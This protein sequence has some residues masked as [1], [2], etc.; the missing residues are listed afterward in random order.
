[1]DD[2]RPHDDSPDLR[3]KIEALEAMLH[4]E[5]EALAE[6]RADRDAWKQQATALLAAPPNR[7]SWWP[8]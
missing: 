7:R 1:M 3:V 8:W 5:R 2:T 6:V 4:R